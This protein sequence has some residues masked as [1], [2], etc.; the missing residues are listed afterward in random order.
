MPQEVIRCPIGKTGHVKIAEG[1]LAI[2]YGAFQFC[3]IESVEF[4]D[5]IVAIADR[6]FSTV[7][8]LNQQ[9]LEKN[10]RILRGGTILGE[11]FTGCDRLQGEG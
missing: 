2:A 6:A 3:E 9:I 7:E 4:P 1:T 8:T 11:I 10:S 5:S